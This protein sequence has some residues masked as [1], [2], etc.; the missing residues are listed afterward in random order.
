MLGMNDKKEEAINA[1]LT[2]KYLVN[3]YN[4][5]HKELSDCDIIMF[6][7]DEETVFARQCIDTTIGNYHVF[8]VGDYNRT[9]VFNEKIRKALI[10]DSKDGLG[11]NVGFCVD[12]DSNIM[13]YMPRALKSSK[14]ENEFN[15]LLNHVKKCS[16]APTCL[17]YML[18]NS[19]NNNGMDE[20]GEVYETLLYFYAFSRV[21]IY[22]LEK[23][24]YKEIEVLTEDYLKADEVWRIM[25]D[26]REKNMEKEKRKKAIHCILLETMILKHKDQKSFNDKMDR[27]IEFM[28]SQVGVYIE[29]VFYACALYLLDSNQEGIR[30]FFAKMQPSSKNLQNNIAGMAWDLFHISDLPT[31]MALESKKAVQ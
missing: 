27:L 15:I 30:K 29:N 17:P 2:E 22:E 3:A 20:P 23:S 28:N 21:P 12:F 6:D 31:E 8:G 19:L 11:V 5:Y 9:M 4:D 18:E 1:V 13:S 7:S 16:N 25:R 14:M 10:S 26:N 24:Q